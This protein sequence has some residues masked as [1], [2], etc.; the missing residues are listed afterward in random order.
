[1]RIA[2]HLDSINYRGTSVAVYDYAKYNQ[3]ILGNE[4]IIVY[5]SSLP[6]EKDMGSEKAVIDKLKED[7]DVL[8]CKDEE[9]SEIMLFEDID[10]AYFIKYGYNDKPLPDVRTA[11]HSV[12]Q[13][14]DPHG[15][16]YA[17]VSEWL[18]KTMGGDIPFVPHI[19]QLPQANDSYR[20]RFNI[21]NDQIVVGRHGG[22][23]SFDLDFVKQQVIELVETTDDYVFLFVNTQP[24]YKHKNIKYIDSVVDLQKKSNFI[25]TC[26]VMLHARQRGESFGL[27]VCEFLFHNKPVLAWEDGIDKNHIELLK[28][29]NLL[30]NIDTLKQK[31]KTIKDVKYDF[32]SIVDPFTPEVVMKKFSE[33]FIE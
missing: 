15:D 3:D 2:F 7:F 8:G 19:V 4:S 16:R 13:A 30:Y 5:N 23:L 26:D 17:Y 29:T 12:F 27:S 14:K 28:D 21:L 6:Y 20:E 31:L 25:N 9:L 24:F 10:I 18:S 22:L 33:V 32:K 1:M 11:V